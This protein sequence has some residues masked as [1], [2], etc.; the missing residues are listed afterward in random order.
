MKVIPCGK[1]SNISGLLKPPGRLC[2]MAMLK[3]L[4]KTC[5]GRAR[6]VRGKVAHSPPLLVWEWWAQH[7]RESKPALPLC[8]GMAS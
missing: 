3:V 7:I 1:K 6:A 2:M 4:G 8:Q 5:L